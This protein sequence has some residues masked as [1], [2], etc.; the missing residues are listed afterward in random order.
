MA[1]RP[2]TWVYSPPKPS[3]PDDFKIE[4]KRKADELVQTFLK[5]SRQGAERAGLVLLSIGRDLLAVHAGIFPWGFV[6]VEALCCSH[7]V[8]DKDRPEALG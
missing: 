7:L 8:V 3:V 2:K 6:D 4:V 1:K 5:P